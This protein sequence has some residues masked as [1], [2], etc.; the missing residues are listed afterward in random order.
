MS[1]DARLGVELDRFTLDD[2]AIDVADGE[3]VAL[4]GPNGAGKTTVLRALMGLVAVDRGWVRMDGTALDDPDAGTWVPTEHRRVGAVFQ[5]LV[6]FPHL[7]ALENVAFGLRAT[8]TAAS[9]A[10]RRAHEWL[11]RLGIR[12]VASA[13][14][15]A[16]SGGQAQRVALAR[17]LVTDPRLLVLDEPLTAL[18]VSTR[19]GV[20]RDLVRHLADF[21]GSALLVTHDPVEAMALA[22][23]IVVVEDGRVSQEGTPDEVRQ[24]PRTRYVADV[25]G[26]NLYRGIASS[27]GLELGDGAVLASAQQLDGPAFAVVHPATVSLHTRQPEGTPRNVWHGVVRHIDPEGDRARV[28]VDGSVPVTAEI[29]TVARSELGLVVGSAVWASVKATEVTLYPA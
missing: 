1:V 28:H 23:R 10:R 29:T 14:P 9:E 24:Q 12:E 17:A 3:T 5:D 11:D 4:L 13:E 26:V 25:V 7:S 27:A 15:R 22:D 6:L 19:P 20:R 8:G 16:L 18:D 21:E 2:V